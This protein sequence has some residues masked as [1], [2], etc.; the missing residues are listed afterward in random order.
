M[1]DSVGLGRPL[2]T[3]K[4]TTAGVGTSSLPPLAEAKQCA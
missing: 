2:R 4:A 3:K 1:A